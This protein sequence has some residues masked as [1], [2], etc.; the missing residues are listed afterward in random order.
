MGANV[1]LGV[2]FTADVSGF[3]SG[4]RFYK[5]AANTGTHTGTLWSAAGAPLA[6]A[7]FSGESTSGWQEATFSSPVAV[8]AGTTYVASYHTTTGHYAATGQGFASAFDNAP[9]H[10]PG[11]AAAGG[12]GVFA[13]G[14]SS[15]PNQTYNSTNYWVD[16]TFTTSGSA[17]TAPGAPTGVSASAGDTSATVSWVAPVDG[18]SPITSYTVTPFVG[19]VAQTPTTVTGAPPATSTVVT[20]LTNGTT[21][22]FTVTAANAVGAGTASAASN[23][24]TPSASGPGCPCT[25]FG[26]TVPGVPDSGDTGANLELGVKFTADVS[27]FVSGVRFYKSASNTGVHSG[28]LWA[29]DGSLLATATF[30]GESA[31]GWQQVTFSSPVAVTAGTTYVASYHTTTGHYA[32]TP[33]GFAAAFDNAPLHAPAS[34]AS[35]GNGVFAYGAGSFPNQSYNDTNYWVDVT[36][37]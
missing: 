11:N 4:V 30:A 2:K 36:L 24:V 16:V 12:N 23:P 29:A 7:T 27:G 31:S 8:T 22:T 19:S 9:L 25:L 6:T 20:G 33:Q 34:G 14:A 10:A 17:P 3:V 13:Y 28:S 21:Y 32:A 37:S 18:G 1:E 26:S 15:F 5:S 35:G